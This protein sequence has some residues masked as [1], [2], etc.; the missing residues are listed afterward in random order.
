MESVMRLECM[1]PGGGTYLIDQGRP[2]LRHQG[3]PTGG[4]ADSSSAQRARELLDLDD[5]AVLLEFTLEGGQW[6]LSGKGQFAITGAD[7]GWRINGRPVEIYTTIDIDG[8]YLLDGGFAERGCRSY[9][10]IRGNW[11]SPRYL[12]SVSPGLPE[13]EKITSGWS[14]LIEGMDEVDYSSDLDIYQ[15]LPELPLTLK[16][17]PGPEWPLLSDEA[18]KYLGEASFQLGQNSNRQGVRLVSDLEVPHPGAQVARMISSP[19]LPGTIQLPPS[20]P[21]VLLNDAQT[22]GGF[23]RVLLVENYADLNLLAQLKPGD[24]VQFVL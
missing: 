3:I 17:T 21:I 10:A 11:K 19:V 9:L 7:M 22:V 16:V 1:K 6:L 5:D 12:G 13:V 15:H 8:D 24:E 20:G 4:P 2:G 14:I 18:R 23:P